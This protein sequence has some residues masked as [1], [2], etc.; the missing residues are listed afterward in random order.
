MDP[1]FRTK[2]EME[3]QIKYTFEEIINQIEDDAE[4]TG[5][6]PDRVLL[7]WDIGR[8][9]VGGGIVYILFAF[10]FIFFLGGL[11]L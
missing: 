4:S 6:D 7:A 8:F 9:I 10:G 5:W 11:L 2:N 3:D 1:C